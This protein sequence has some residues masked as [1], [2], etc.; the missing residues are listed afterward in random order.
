MWEDRNI[1]SECGVVDLVNEDA[2]EGSGFV[3]GIGLKLRV[4]LNDECRGDCR[5]QAGLII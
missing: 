3:V 2:E 1:I 5:E 4:D